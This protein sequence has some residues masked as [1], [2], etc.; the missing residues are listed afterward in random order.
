MHNATI[1]FISWA[2]S[3]T[4]SSTAFLNWCSVRSN[5][6]VVSQEIPVGILPEFF[7]NAKLHD[8][9]VDPKKKG[10]RTTDDDIYKNNND[11]RRKVARGNTVLTFTVNG[12]QLACVPIFALRKFTGGFGDEDEDEVA[13]SSNN[14]ESTD[15]DFSN[16]VWR[17]FFVSPPENA[18]KVYITD[19]A[20]GSAA[21]MAAIHVGPINQSQSDTI[22]PDVSE[23]VFIG[24][25]KNVHMMFRTSEDILKYDGSRYGVA[26]KVCQTFFCYLI[27]QPTA[28]SKALVLRFIQSIY[29][30]RLTACFELLDPNDMHVED[31]TSH[32]IIDSHDNLEH[33]RETPLLLPPSIRLYALVS[34]ERGESDDH[35]I[36]EEL[37]QSFKFARECKIKTVGYRV[38]NLKGNSD[39][40]KDDVLNSAISEIRKDYGHEG[41]VLYFAE[42][43]DRIIGLLKKKT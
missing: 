1:N 41:A 12:E 16:V 36:C 13:L 27:N 6:K 29:D 21:H 37:G 8:I 19:K 20:N 42:A 39:I 4:A 26:R 11:I 34:F 14:P 24:G 33:L 35:Y 32:L 18:C 28:E 22:V 43:N 23:F 17:R 30:R 3:S 15:P 25:S 7:K 5:V 38:I 31:L 9:K 2:R 40:S 10:K